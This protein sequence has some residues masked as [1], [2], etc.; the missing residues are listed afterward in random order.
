MSS[1]MSTL[2]IK[3]GVDDLY[4]EVANVSGAT[5]FLLR[6]TDGMVAPL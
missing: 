4:E 6:D 5:T 1:S 3:Q 2:L